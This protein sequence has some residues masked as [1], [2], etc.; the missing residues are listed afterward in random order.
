MLRGSRNKA[1]RGELFLAVPVGYLKLSSEEIIQEP[2]EQARDMVQLVF[3]KFE[4]LGVGPQEGEKE[5]P[6]K[7]SLR[8]RVV[9]RCRG[10]DFRDRHASSLYGQKRVWWHGTRA[11]KGQGHVAAKRSH[12]SSD[13]GVRC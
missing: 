5:K 1:E 11:L 9:I 12:Q 10:C 13:L 6:L 3:D 4:E 2:D 8:R 7:P